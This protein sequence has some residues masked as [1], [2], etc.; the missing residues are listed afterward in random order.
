[1]KKIHL[2]M[3]F[4]HKLLLYTLVF[5]LFA[6]QNYNFEITVAEG[7]IINSEYLQKAEDSE[8]ALICM[9]LYA[10]GNECKKDTSAIK[11]N[12]LKSLHIDNECNTQHLEFL[13]KWFITNELMLIKLQKCPNLPYNFAIQNHIEKIGII[14]HNDTLTIVFNVKGVNE[15]QEKTWEFAQ[16]DM[17]IVKNKTLLKI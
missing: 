17:Y 13:K 10:Y 15:S 9:Y 12:I 14:K 11:C 8:I 7:N 4:M 6:C 1:M 16:K 3:K 2:R 5:F